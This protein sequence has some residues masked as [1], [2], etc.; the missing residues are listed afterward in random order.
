[1]MKRLLSL[2]MA[3]VLVIGLVGMA[4]QAHAASDMKA[5]EDCIQFIK[6]FEG[7]SGKPYKDSDGKYTIG[8]GTRC[9][10]DLV[11]KYMAD[12]M[13]K[14]EADR[15]LREKLVTYESEVNRFIDR[16]GL[17]YKQQQFDAL[18]SLV[19]NCGSSWLSKGS[20]LVKALTTGAQG[21][22][23]IYA[24]SIYS[25]S[26]GSRSLGHVR[27]RLAEA[28]IYLNGLYSRTVPD[29]FAYVLY[30]PQGGQIHANG[31][32]YNVQGYDAAETTQPIATASREGYVFKG[33]YTAISGGRQV[34]VLDMTTQNATLYARWE[35]DDSPADPSDPTEPTEPDVPTDPREPVTVTVTGSTVNLREGAGLDYKVVGSANRGDKL[36]VTDTAKAD[37]YLWGK[38]DAGWIALKHTD[39]VP[40]VEETTEATEPSTEAT[41]PSTEATEPSTEATEPAACDHDY[42]ISSRKEPT[43]K[44]TGSVSYTCKKCGDA[45]EETLDKLPHDYSEATCTKPKTCKN[46]GR[47]SGE[48]K[49]HTYDAPTCTQSQ[50]CK[51]CGQTSGEALGHDFAPATC[52]APATCKVCGV[53]SGSA[54]SHKYSSASCSKPATCSRCG[55]TKGEALGHDYSPAT[56]T[57]PKTCKVC[58]RR[59]GEALGHKYNPA[60][61]TEAATCQVCGYT[62]GVALGHSYNGEGQCHCGA[63]DPDFKP[64]EIIKTYGTVIKTDSLNIRVTPDGAICGSLKLGQKVE[65]LEQK[66]VGDRLWGRCSQGW[67]CMRS[68]VK[69]ETVTEEAVPPVDPPSVPDTVTK[70]YGTIVRTDTLN[71]RENPDGTVVGVLYRGDKVEILEQKLVAGRMWGRTEKG[72]I[73]LR[74]YVELE[75]VTEG[76]PQQPETPPVEKP[77][78]PTTVE[79]TYGTVINTNSLNVRLEPDGQIVAKLYRGDRV[80]I[81]EQKMVDGRMWGLCE[82]GWICLRSY[83][84]LETITETVGGS[85]PSVPQEPEK[86]PDVPPQEQPPQK[87]PQE[88]VVKTYAT[89]IITDAL[90]VRV[91]PDGDKCGSLSLGT[92]IEVLEQKFVS[93]RLWGRTEQ[94]W[95]C[96]RSYVKLETVTET[97]GGEI[98][99][100][101]TGTITATSLNIRAEASTGSAVVGMLYRGDTVTILETKTVNGTEWGRIEQGWISMDYV[102]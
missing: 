18:V 73:C 10:D 68:Y 42:Q 21:S 1:M 101:R 46:C 40:P 35:K 41:E 45:Y 69:L 67:I 14:E 94:G 83:V 75:V 85:T 51:V 24:F 47:T 30:N 97:V 16:N 37:D 11:E 49:G 26:G 60:T 62:S 43:C 22:D 56:C 44:A 4:P 102:A 88:T 38:T 64:A 17:S 63:K 6:E 3:I 57:K 70:T 96:M 36:I 39:Y 65:I 20:T 7:F 15:E 81:L 50:I 61:C 59:E 80:E 55:K 5:S 23:L 74:S 25:M 77:Q 98:S 95:I 89:V 92:R 12:P 100:V 58:G 48:A 93:G 52:T 27:R 78:E 28:N 91:T 99:D 34:T 79:K 54:L 2:C 31:G 71:V 32:S 19:F 82:Q 84:K 29:N 72:W 66:M 8:Y 90:N 9:P 13:T 53:T 86:D 76:E 33:W 87:D